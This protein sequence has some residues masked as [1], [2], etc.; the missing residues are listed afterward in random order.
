LVRACCDERSGWAFGTILDTNDGASGLRAGGG[1][2]GAA[3]PIGRTIH[4]GVPLLLP[5]RPRGPR[6]VPLSAAEAWSHYV[7]LARRRDFAPADAVAFDAATG[8]CIGLYAHGRIVGVAK[9]ID[10]SSER[11]IVATRAPQGAERMLAWMCRGLG[12]PSCLHAGQTLPI[13]YVSYRAAEPGVED[14]DAILAH[15]AANERHRFSHAFVGLS[16]REAAGRCDRF[17]LRISSTTF[18]FGV[19]PAGLS[20]AFHEL[21]LV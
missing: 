7:R 13:A 3:R 8:D 21:A 4:L 20:L 12:V 5:R 16:E 10:Q 2:I 11:R 19:P 6:V 17:A 1:M 9:L 18:A 14:L 15:L